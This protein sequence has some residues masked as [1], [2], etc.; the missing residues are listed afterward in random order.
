MMEKTSVERMDDMRITQAATDYAIRSASASRDA[1]E[2]YLA[3]ELFVDTDAE[4]ANGFGDIRQSVR[5]SRW[6]GLDNALLVRANTNRK[7]LRLR[8]VPIKFSFS[9]DYRNEVELGQL[10]I[11][12]TRYLLDMAG[13]PR[14]IKAKI[15]KIDDTGKNQQVEAIS[16]FFSA[17]EDA[18]RFG[19]VAPNG[20]NNYTTAT[21][22]QQ[23]KYCFVANASD[24]MSNG[25]EGYYI[26]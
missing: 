8:N 22:E 20:L 18:R 3:G 15:T 6:M 11:I 19:F 1:A 4:S 12:Q 2:S 26:S 13:N 10:V 9:L 7:L 24:L 23:A 25:D 16:A 17:E 21:A 14:A 5:R